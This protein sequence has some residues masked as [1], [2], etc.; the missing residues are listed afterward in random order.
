MSIMRRKTYE[1]EHDD[2]SLLDIAGLSWVDPL[3]FV[4]ARLDRLADDGQSNLGPG[5]PSDHLLQLLVILA[6]AAEDALLKLNPFRL[7]VVSRGRW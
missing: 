3:E 4:V 7:P 6:L 1:V 2:I 5:H